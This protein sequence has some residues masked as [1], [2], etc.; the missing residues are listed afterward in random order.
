MG[1]AGRRGS[2]AAGPGGVLE[3][4]PTRTPRLR[5]VSSPARWF[6][7]SQVGQR[8]HRPHD[9]LCLPSFLGL[10]C[11]PTR[12]GTV[13][14]STSHAK[15]NGGPCTED[16]WRHPLLRPP[17]HSCLDSL[18]PQCPTQGTVHNTK[19]RRLL[20]P[21]IWSQSLK[22]V[23]ASQPLNHAARQALLLSSRDSRG[24]QDPGYCSRAL[25]LTAV[26][27]GLGGGQT[28]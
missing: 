26:S 20:M 25:G 18:S 11:R 7:G 21:T 17:S 14:I 1:T 3:E 27:A 6:T 16:P 10:S 2:K 24:S 5:E 15:S 8:G 22:R 4:T 13:G 23:S 28:A 9:T 12:A 19:S